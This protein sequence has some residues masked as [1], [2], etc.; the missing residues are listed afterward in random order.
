MNS[1]DTPY[2]VGFDVT[3]LVDLTSFEAYKDFKF[4]N[5]DTYKVGDSVRSKLGFRTDT[6]LGS[7]D[8]SVTDAW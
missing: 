5:I 1:V 6:G 8:F 2:E 7:A 4:N 3:N